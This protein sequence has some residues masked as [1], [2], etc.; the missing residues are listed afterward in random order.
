MFSY[1][2]HAQVN[3]RDHFL[4]EVDVHTVCRQEP[5]HVIV[6]NNNLTS[7][8]SSGKRVGCLFQLG[9]QFAHSIDLL[10]A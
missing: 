10:V 8:S 2:V 9:C 1:F 6:I 7:S 4:I 3:V 5:V